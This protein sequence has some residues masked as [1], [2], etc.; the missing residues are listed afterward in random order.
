M[1]INQTKK[2]ILSDCLFIQQINYLLK[3]Q[4]LNGCA[5]IYQLF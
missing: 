3:L 1:Y 2:A 5:T 4:V